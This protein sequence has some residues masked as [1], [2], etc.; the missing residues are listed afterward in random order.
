[1]GPLL[2]W[3]GHVEKRGN[4]GMADELGSWIINYLPDEGG[5]LTGKL[6]LTEDEV[7]FRAMYDSSFR[8]VARN[9][10]LAAGT[11]AAS[12]GS[13]TFLREDGSEAEIVLPRGAIAKA[14]P[15]KKGMMKQVVLTTADG[16][17]FVFEY[18]MLS[19]KK[20]VAAING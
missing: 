12:G 20:I 16:Q 1:M 2:P 10:G 14:E 13:L 7:K 3:P 11:L 9:I 5:R 4:A 19:V 8:T 18:G 6:I 15:T 17:Q